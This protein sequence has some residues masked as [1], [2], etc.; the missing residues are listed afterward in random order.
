MNG[1]FAFFLSISQVEESQRCA[2][3]SEHT[4]MDHDLNKKN[5]GGWIDPRFS[6]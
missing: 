2:P 4:K 6:F 3:A 5:A 1:L